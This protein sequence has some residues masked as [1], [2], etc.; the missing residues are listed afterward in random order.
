MTPTEQVR[1][2]CKEVFEKAKTLYG[3]DISNRTTIQFNLKGRV[4]GMASHQ[5]FLFNGGRMNLRFNHDML[6]RGDPDLL[7]DMLEDTVPHEIAHLVCFA[8]PLLGRDHNDGWARVCRALGGTGNRT[9]DNKVVFGKGTTYE[10]TTDR[11]HKVRV[12]DRNHT[13]IQGGGKLTWRKGK[14][15]VTQSCAYSIVGYRGQ[16]LQQPIVKK[17]VADAPATKEVPIETF[18]MPV[19][20]VVRPVPVVQQPAL[21]PPAAPVEQ[22]VFAAGQ[23][24]AAVSRSIMLSGYRAVDSYETIITAMIRA[25]GYTRQLARATFGANAAKVG[26]P[27]NWGN[28]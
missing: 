6:T 26:I 10:Y 14:G 18:V 1:A 21:I 12:N 2:K 27:A 15:S 9:H 22:R 4:A 8:N 17:P 5:G 28:K 20:P 19:V 16:T 13:Y 24:K 23:S 25:N 11:G 3:V 7:K